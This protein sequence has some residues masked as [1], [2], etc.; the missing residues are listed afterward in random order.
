MGFIERTE[1]S[2]QHWAERTKFFSDQVKRLGEIETKLLASD[3]GI[4]NSEAE[5]L[6]IAGVALAN[7]ANE[8]SI[9]ATAAHAVM[10]KVERL[11]LCARCG[12]NKARESECGCAR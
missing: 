3:E 2:F 9:R 7:E 12:I 10:L 5:T 8:C 4:T 6:R 1:R 11:E